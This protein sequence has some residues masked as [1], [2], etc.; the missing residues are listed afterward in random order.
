M[1]NRA[2]QRSFWQPKLRTGAAMS[3]L[4]WAKLLVR[5]VPFELWRDRLGYANSDIKAAPARARKLAADVEWAAKR[6]PFGTKCLPRAM[7]LS[8]TLRG[9]GMPNTV[10][11]AVRPDQLRQSSDPLHAWVE[12]E[13]ETILGELPGPWIETLRIGA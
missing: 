13:G 12:V 3:R 11:I 2:G 4:C 6:L 1:T 9:K 7:A 5:F 10:V 8:W